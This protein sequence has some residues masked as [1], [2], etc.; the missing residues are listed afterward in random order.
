M[1]VRLEVSHNKAN[2]KR[3]VLERDAV[4]GRGTDCNLRIA[5]SSIS[6]QHCKISITPTEVFVRDLGS[7]NGTYVDGTKIEPNEDVLVPPGT[8]IALGSVK[9]RVLYDAPAPAPKV[10]SELGSTVELLAVGSKALSDNSELI[11]SDSDPKPKTDAEPA[12]KE[13]KVDPKF[14]AK[15]A[16][17]AAAEAAQLA[18]DE[19]AEVAAEAAQVE[20]T[21]DEEELVESGAELF[22]IDTDS[23]QVADASEETLVVEPGETPPQVED[24]LVTPT[25]EVV[26]NIAETISATPNQLAETT[27]FVLGDAAAQA[28]P[29]VEAAEEDEYEYEYEEEEYEEEVEEE[30]SPQKKGLLGSVMGLFGRKKAAAEEEEYEE[31]EE[32][33]VAGE[34]AGEEEEVEY[35][36][37]EEDVE[38]TEA[39]AADFLGNVG[40]DVPEEVSGE[41]EGLGDFLSEFGGD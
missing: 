9:F 37:E 22:P 35:E 18:A 17:A 13:D 5:S 7:S 8:K 23:D 41:D 38:E 16:A 4:I 12:A 34:A 3:I 29:N 32:E 14:A 15:K 26:E 36:Y 40:E 19:A 2:V 27:D 28:E 31:Y 24:E 21:S 11:E 1:Q 25:D 39:A 10:Q 20:T 6:R 33:E 30:E